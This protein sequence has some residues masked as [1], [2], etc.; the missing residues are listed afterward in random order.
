MAEDPTADLETL[1]LFLE[2]NQEPKTDDDENKDNE[3][4]NE[5]ESK[6]FWKSFKDALDLNI[7]G[8]DGQQR[9]LSIIAGSF[10]YSQLHDN[11][12]VGF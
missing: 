3:I 9:I 7:R 6:K 1:D 8:H 5:F 2:I 11:L 10:T 12:N 4:T